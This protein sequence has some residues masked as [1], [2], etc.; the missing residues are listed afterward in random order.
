MT[1]SSF[2]AADHFEKRVDQVTQLLAPFE[3]LRQQL[4]RH[5]AE[6]TVQARQARLELALAYLPELT[7]PAIERAERLTGFR[8]FTRRNPLAA[9]AKHADVLRRTVARVVADE[10]YRRREYILGPAGELTLERT[11][12]AD[13]MEPWVAECQR[14]EG[15]ESFD[16]LVQTGYDTPA[17]EISFLTSYY[18]RLWAAGDR[19]CE[20][21]E[22]EDFGDDVLPAYR[23][24][25]AERQRWQA[26]LD[27]VDAKVDAIHALVREHDQAVAML[28]RLPELVYQQ[29]VQ[30]LVAFFEN[31]DLA[32]LAQWLD[33]DQEDDRASKMGLRKAAGL[34]AK[35]GYLDEL[36][37]VAVKGVI[38]DLSQRRAKYQNKVHKF[39]RRGRQVSTTDIERD[40]RFDEKMPKFHQ[41]H[42]RLSKLVIRIVDYDDYHRFELD[43]EPDLWWYEFTR[44]RPSRLTPRLRS[45]YDEHP[46][47]RPQHDPALREAAAAGALAEATAATAAADDIGYVS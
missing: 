15:L 3:Q 24:V 28:P 2:V 31:A 14:F 26:E 17:F 42:A 21:L 41:R 6:V 44:S 34:H 32:L 33:D 47:H 40:Q 36:H 22:M 20:T 23:K 25:E 9:L 45:W 8:G 29:S 13:M 46:E 12:T 16:D 1:I 11:E 18:W 43:N 38:T 27:R 5:K 37:E 35:L 4:V 30:L 19:I 39:R 10:R 7:A